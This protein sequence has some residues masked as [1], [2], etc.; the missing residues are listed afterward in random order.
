M[1]F[2]PI[3]EKVIRL[4][5]C[6]LLPLHSAAF[7]LAS[8]EP[9]GLLANEE[10]CRSTKSPRHHASDPRQ[11]VGTL[12]DKTTSRSNLDKIADEAREACGEY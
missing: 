6:P 5:Q 12:S 2:G 7:G 9:R 3:A 8:E 4:V 11:L 1:V 10:S